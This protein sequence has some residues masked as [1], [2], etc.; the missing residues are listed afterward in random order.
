MLE[1]PFGA[2]QQGYILI[3]I[4]LT[5]MRWWKPLGIRELTKWNK[6][7]LIIEINI[8]LSQVI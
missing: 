1:K 3:L 2:H 7:N 5:I 6:I 4:L 8:G